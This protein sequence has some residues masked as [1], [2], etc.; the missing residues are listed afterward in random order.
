[1][2]K[3]VLLSFLL[4][5][6]LT[7][8]HAD[9]MQR[10]DVKL[11]NISLREFFS[12]IEKNYPY[13]FMYD[14]TEI[15][16]KE[17]ISVNERNQPITNVLSSVLKDKGINYE[18]QGYQI[19]LSKKDAIDQSDVRQAGRKTVTGKVLDENGDPVI[20]ANIVEKGT[21]NGTVTNIDGDF[22]L[23]VE[24]NAVIQISYIGYLVQ[25]VNSTGR[26]SVNIVLQEDSKTLDE[27]VVVGY[28]TMRKRDLTG[29]V[30]SIKSEDIQRS[31]VTSLD[32]AIQGKAAGVQVS[33]ASS[34]PGG[35]VLIRVRGGNSLSSS[36][37]PLYV[38]DG[39]PVSAG[40]SAGGNGTAQNP[41]ATLNTA[42]IASIE[43]LKDASATAIYGARGANGVVLI[44]T[45]R[46]DIGRPR[47]TLDAYH[48]VQTV[49]KK[50]DMMNAREYATLV[51]EARANDG[52]S[53]VFPNPNNPY[54]FPDISALG[55]GVDYQ[56]EVFTSA[57]TQNY[58]LSVVGGNDG[59]RYSV[60]GGYFGQ[61]GIIKNSNFNRA[62]FRSNL[63]IKIVPSLTVST[64]I[65]ASHS[66]AN[67]MPSEGDGG[68]G[69]GGV[70][71]GAV[72]MPASVP[73]YDADGN[74][75]MT[76]P[77]PGGT[78]SNNPVATVNHYKDNQEI[79]RFL[80]SVDANW[81]IMK[82]LT[83]KITF[84]ADLST[85][86]RAFYWPKQTHRGNSK[87]GE[88]NQ[89]YRKDVSY[90]NE[91]ILTYN[92]VLGDHS[93]NVVGGYTWQIFHYKHFEASSTGYSTDL[94]LANNLG[95]GTTY[96][97]PGSNRSQNQLA[98]YL[99]RLNYIYKD[100]YLFTLTARA[101]G[102]SKFG[103][104]NKW[105][106]FPSFAVAW[107]ASEEA[108]LREVDWLSNLKVRASYGKTGN[109]NID[110]YKSLAMLGTMNYALGGVLNSGVGPNNIPNPDLKWETTA[111]TDVGLDIGLF[112]NRL[113]LV[114]D[115][116]Y[117]KTT[118]LLW[119]ISTPSSVGFGSIF[120]NIGSLENKGLEI[121]LGA[122][123]F[124]GEFKW[125]TQM[126][127]S[128]NRNKVLEIPGYTPSTQGTLSG[129]LKVNGSWLEP[130]LP[131]GV[132][133][134]LKYD[135]VFQDQ[136]Q[137]EA[138]PRSSANDKLGDAR[139]VDKNGDGKI[140]YTDDRMIVGDPNPDFIYGWTNNFSFKGFDFSVY[141]QGSYGNDIINIQRAE[142]NISGPWGNQRRE[143]LNRWTPTNTN[144]SVPRAR[145]TVDPLLLQSDWLIED[146]SYMRVK[147][148][149]LGYT[150]G[151][152]RF[153][154]S[155]RLYVTGQ[156]LF[157][158]TNYSG[159]DPE[160]NSQGN[161][162]L[163]LGVDYNAYPSAKA[164][165]FGVNISF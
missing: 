89:R 70:V 140:N 130:G 150:F 113:S 117:K 98:S 37:E 139:F 71:H 11:N 136:A 135:G 29:S 30:S 12:Y 14:N 22:T 128:R 111:S 26:N 84:G 82:D 19:I 158:I 54:Y 95:A 94:Y 7:N 143:I 57:P 159:F 59:I 156:N 105:S 152:V 153:M 101:D 83:L 112:N 119:N 131:V 138:G 13:T 55:E 43:I 108:F 97:Q 66:W 28:G 104:N 53:P 25:E 121:T 69:T 56:D 5:F 20:G 24:N 4:F 102:S 100:R 33:Q 67:G 116:Y 86:N 65:T 107:R 50:L 157:T 35:R 85:A 73:I 31:P 42:D 80:G 8:V 142:T 47:V 114:V 148:M 110:N 134:L 147:T 87:N 145:V 3:K 9:N 99:G 125:N 92:K 162:N 51:N 23:T 39:F 154:N 58:N 106:F 146:G 36:N 15:N 144:T 137:L 161:S 90:L 38:V 60:G 165:L 120:K 18:I 78:P 122:D 88:A 160:V 45:K 132:W 103:A 133:N 93:F 40:G 129:H 10:V 17:R 164:V 64:N 115:Y 61:D 96:G 46:G 109:Q 34:A 2:C 41:L 1:M 76:N 72:V 74:Y 49:A 75:T 16:D 163:Q 32:Q 126:N 118:D 68:G 141:L 27:I 149:T 91:N 151:N 79:D 155:L 62:S 81:E 63:D 48:G 6:L 127:W 124:T 44:T 77:T 52:Q 123:V 21:T